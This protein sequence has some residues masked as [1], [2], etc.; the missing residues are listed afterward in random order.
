MIQAAI[1]GGGGYTA[2]ELIRILL[3]HPKVELAWVHSNSQSGKMISDIHEDLI[4]E[5]SLHFTKD[6]DFDGVDVLFL[7]SGHG[8]SARFVNQQQLPENLVVIDLSQDFRLDESFVYGLPELHRSQIQGSKRIA[9]C[10]CFA[11]AIQLGL[12][13]L[14][15]AG[16]LQSAVHITA[17]TGATGAGQSPGATTHFSW[18]NNNLSVYK[19]FGHQHLAE[20]K[21][22]LSALQGDHLP[23]LHFIPM[24]GDFARGIF[25]SMYTQC[26]LD[27]EALY[28]LYEQ[29]YQSAPFTHVIRQNPNLKQVVNTNRALVH[30]EKHGDQVLILSLID[31]LL[32]G[33]SG[34]AV[35][36]MNLIF[37]LPESTGLRLKAMVF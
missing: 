36:N 23:P 28:E 32:K 24:R 16:L 10:G 9:N 29:Y 27:E 33:A 12:L 17:V 22:S 3:Y 8:E 30:L 37:Q 21:R 6:M 14:A 7:C 18:R 1:I 15:K 35:Q 26:D 2:G 20:I 11:T 4:G 19:P 34:Q 5:T 31:N 25:A 13:P